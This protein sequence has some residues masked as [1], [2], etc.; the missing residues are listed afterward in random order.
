M[1]RG[2]ATELAQSHHGHSGLVVWIDAPPSFSL[3]E[4]LDAEW[5]V[6]HLDVDGEVSP[7]RRRGQGPWFVDVEPGERRIV[8]T[9][10]RSKRELLTAVVTARSEAPAMVEIKPAIQSGSGRFRRTSVPRIAMRQ[11]LRS[12]S[13]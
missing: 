8:V 13:R 7:P 6:V 12:Q 5:L 1:R 9:E 10:I 2:K 11:T 4:R 3:V